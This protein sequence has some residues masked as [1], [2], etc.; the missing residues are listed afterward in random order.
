MAISILTTGSSVLL[1]GVGVAGLL[2]VLEAKE[3]KQGEQCQGA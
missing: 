1:A 2:G 3:R